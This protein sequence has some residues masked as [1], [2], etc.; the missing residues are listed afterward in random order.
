MAPS[1]EDRSQAAFTVNENGFSRL[2]LMDMETR[3]FPPVEGLPT[4]LVG[5]MEFSPDGSRLGMTLNTPQ[6]PSDSFVLDLVEDDPLGY[7]EITRWTYS[8]VGGL[9][10]ADFVVPELVSYP[11]FD[12]G[13]GGPDAIPAWV[14]KPAGEGPFPVIIQIHGG[15][16]SQ[17]RPSFSST[18]QMWI[19]ES[20]CCGH[21]PECARL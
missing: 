6:T 18:Y 7:G 5:G 16:E 1:V 17:S 3:E 11:T 4:G 8:E 12:S 20:R 9:N 2:Y 21:P 10:T 19:E 15:P 14:Y 13:Q